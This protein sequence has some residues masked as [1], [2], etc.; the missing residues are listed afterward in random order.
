MIDKLT[1]IYSRYEQLEEQLGNPDLVSD[2]SRYKKVN[3]EYKD[4]KPLIECYLIYA[5][6]IGN[7]NT[8]QEMLKDN[9][10]DK[11]KLILSKKGYL[12]PYI[13]KTK[14]YTYSDNFK[15]IIDDNIE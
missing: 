11:H 9:D 8:S 4:L 15:Y 2:L 6:I 5:D 10:F 7:I 1:A 3:K 14:S 13:D 12:M